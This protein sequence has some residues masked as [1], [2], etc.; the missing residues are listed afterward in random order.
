MNNQTTPSVSKY[1][2]T[3]ILWIISHTGDGL[4]VASAQQLDAR[5]LRSPRNSVERRWG[6]VLAPPTAGN[7]SSHNDNYNQ[8]G[9]RDVYMQVDNVNFAPFSRRKMPTFQGDI[10]NLSRPKRRITERYVDRSFPYVGT[11]AGFPAFS[12]TVNTVGL[13]TSCRRPASAWPGMESGDIGR[14]YNLVEC[15]HEARS[16]SKSWLGSGENTFS[17]RANIGAACRKH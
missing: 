5:G 11:F 8:R 1:L 9:K 17:D 6:C 12:K 2:S 16:R 4:T 7:G 14:M 13:E 3:R 15:S 10:V